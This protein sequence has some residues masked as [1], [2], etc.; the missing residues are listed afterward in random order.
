VR[1]ILEAGLA[2][3]P[4]LEA[5]PPAVIDSMFLHWKQVLLQPLIQGAF[6]HKLN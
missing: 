6:T 1:V 2:A 4:V 5:G 3:I